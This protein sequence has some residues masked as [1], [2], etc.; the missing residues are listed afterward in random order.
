MVRPREGRC[1][2]RGIRYSTVK[3]RTRILLQLIDWPCC[4]VPSP[5]ANQYEY[6]YSPKSL[7]NWEVPKD[8]ETGVVGATSRCDIGLQDHTPLSLPPCSE[9]M[10][11]MK[12][13]STSG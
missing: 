8:R 13:G 12:S 4:A 2:Y 6:N 3:R 7:G 5:A 11:F 1:P 9:I 10:I